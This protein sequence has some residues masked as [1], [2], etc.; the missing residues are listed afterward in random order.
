MNVP[1]N[2][3][4]VSVYERIHL[5]NREF[6]SEDSEGA[7]EFVTENKFKVRSW[8][9]G[10]NLQVLNKAGVPEVTSLLQVVEVT[11]TKVGFWKSIFNAPD[12]EERSL[13]ALNSVSEAIQEDARSDVGPVTRVSQSDFLWEG[14]PVTFPKGHSMHGVPNVRELALKEDHEINGSFNHLAVL[15]SEWEKMV[16]YASDVVVK[17]LDGIPQIPMCAL[18][19]RNNPVYSEVS[20][21]YFCYLSLDAVGHGHY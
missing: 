14:S 6:D 9:E 11:Q 18:A 8:T 5:A 16:D 19:M 1:I 2:H 21:G 4:P 3:N 10:I 13:S 20:L 12:S 17:G 7:Y 15:I